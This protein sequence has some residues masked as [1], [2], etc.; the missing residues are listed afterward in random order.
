MAIWTLI[1][2]FG[3]AFLSVLLAAHLAGRWQLKNW[4]FQQRVADSEKLNAETKMLFDD[5]VSLASRRHFRTRR[6]Y[7]ALQHGAP[8][9]IAEALNVYDKALG[10]WNEAELSWKVRFVKK[11]A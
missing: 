3:L 11:S 2:N 6:L 10:D 9:K 5:L 1:K 4:L 7:W 8:E